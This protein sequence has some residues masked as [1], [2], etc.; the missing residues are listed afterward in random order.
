MFTATHAYRVVEIPVTR[1]YPGGEKPP[2]K[3]SGFRG[4]LSI[5]RELVAAATGGFNPR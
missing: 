2:T 4:K 5:L 1:A 3:I